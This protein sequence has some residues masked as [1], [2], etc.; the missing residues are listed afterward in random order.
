[1]FLPGR[2]CWVMLKTAGGILFE[3]VGDVGVEGD[4]IAV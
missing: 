2:R 3:G 1:M 4:S